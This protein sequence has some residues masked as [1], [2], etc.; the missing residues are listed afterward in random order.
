MKKLL[1]TLLAIANIST[2]APFL[3]D[4]GVLITLPS[5]PDVSFKQGSDF[6]EMTDGNY[7]RMRGLGDRVEMQSLSTMDWS[8]DWKVVYP[9]QLSLADITDIQ[10]SDIGTIVATARHDNM[11]QYAVSIVRYLRNGQ[12]SRLQVVAVKPILPEPSSY[13]LLAGLLAFCCVALRRRGMSA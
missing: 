1:I 6:V 12:V 9:N 5:N 2:A 7:F 4:T 10:E 13:A 11:K 8:F 3:I